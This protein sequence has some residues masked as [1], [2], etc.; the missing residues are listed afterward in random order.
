MFREK[1]FTHF[2]AFIQ[3]QG[4]RRNRCCFQL[5]EWTH[6]TKVLRRLSS[7]ICH[8]GPAEPRTTTAGYEYSRCKFAAIEQ[9]FEAT[10]RGVLSGVLPRNR[11]GW[12]LVFLAE[13]TVCVNEFN[14]RRLHSKFSKLSKYKDLFRQFAKLLTLSNPRYGARATS[15]FPRLQCAR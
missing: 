5:V 8:P 1:A 9:S 3:S 13:P 7:L 6:S 14:L 2:N 4:C 12:N 15:S 11:T 10:F